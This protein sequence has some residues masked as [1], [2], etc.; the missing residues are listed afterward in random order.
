M[1]NAPIRVYVAGPLT[2]SGSVA[3]NIRRAIDA[4]ERLRRGGLIPFVPHLY[5]TSWEVVCPANSY[6]E[7]LALDLAWLDACDVMVRLSGTSR[8][9]DIEEAHARKHGIPIYYE[10]T[11]DGIQHS[12]I[13]MLISSVCAG[14][15][16]PRRTGSLAALQREMPSWQNHNF[17]GRPGHWPLLGMVEE[18]GELAHAWLKRAQGIRGTPEQHREA[19]EDAIVDLFTFGVDFACSEHIDLDKAIAKVWPK[20]RARDW[21]RYPKHGVPPAEALAKLEA[22]RAEIDREIEALRIYA[23]SASLV[24]DGDL[25]AVPNDYPGWSKTRAVQQTGE[26]G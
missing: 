7:W 4:A 16:A 12:G 13:S 20:V 21:R 2:S 24:L 23:E 9:A 26:E 14:E 15:I 6:D 5:A 1:D 17:P 8:G 25:P 3:V 10:G 19:I 22:K 11:F 18:L